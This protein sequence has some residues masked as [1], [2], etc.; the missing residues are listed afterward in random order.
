MNADQHANLDSL[1][2]QTPGESRVTQQLF[3]TSPCWLFIRKRETKWHRVGRDLTLMKSCTQL[4]PLCFLLFKRPSFKKIAQSILNYFKPL[5][6]YTGQELIKTIKCHF[7]S[8]TLS[9]SYKLYHS[10]DVPQYNF[11]PIYKYVGCLKKFFYKR[12]CNNYPYANIL[13]HAYFYRIDP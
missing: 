12:Y 11:P 10:K 1:G 13:V 6:N 8:L 2:P 5:Q 4:L 9:I 7:T 3:P